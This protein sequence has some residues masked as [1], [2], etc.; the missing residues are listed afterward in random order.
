MRVDT[1]RD[2][3]VVWDPEGMY[4]DGAVIDGDRAGRL[5]QRGVVTLPCLPQLFEQ[6]GVGG[7]SKRSWGAGLPLDSLAPRMV[8]PLTLYMPE[9]GQAVHPPRGLHWRA[10][11]VLDV[12]DGVRPPTKP[13]FDGVVRFTA[14]SSQRTP[15]KCVYLEQGS[16]SFTA[17]DLGPADAHG[18]WTVGGE[19]VVSA[20]GEGHYGFALWAGAPGLRVA[21]VAATMTTASA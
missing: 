20:P 14:D 5:A 15:N 16:R 3:V 19:G 7:F 4:W 21:W 9:T 8:A 12:R 6:S 10:R 13:L 11:L 17:R 1:S 18:G 2:H